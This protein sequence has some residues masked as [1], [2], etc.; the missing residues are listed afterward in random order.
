MVAEFMIADRETTKLDQ[1]LRRLNR[2]LQRTRVRNFVFDERISLGGNGWFFD[3][4]L[5][6]ASD[7]AGGCKPSGQM[8]DFLHYAVNEYGG[9]DNL[10]RFMD[11]K[12]DF[13]LSLS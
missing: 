3:R 6:L 11:I 9:I 7:K 10:L 12:V 2:R 5:V 4:Q 13:V 8:P 1:Y